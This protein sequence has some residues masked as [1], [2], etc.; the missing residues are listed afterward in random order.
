MVALK[1]LDCVAV[2]CFDV[3]YH[4]KVLGFETVHVEPVLGLEVRD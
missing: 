4:L 1:V 2:E 3:S